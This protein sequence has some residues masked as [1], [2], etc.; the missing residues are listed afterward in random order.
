MDQQ[1][2]L[3][4]HQE[5]RMYAN[6][7]RTSLCLCLEGDPQRS[8]Y[9]LLGGSWSSQG[10]ELE[11]NKPQHQTPAALPSCRPPCPSTH[12]TELPRAPHWHWEDH[13]FGWM[14]HCHDL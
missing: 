12:N 3:R 4:P 5:L 14:H 2:E 11:A 8:Q 1:L 9:S 6:S 7:F 13:I 10:T